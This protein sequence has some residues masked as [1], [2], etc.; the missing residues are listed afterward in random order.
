MKVPERRKRRREILDS[1][2]T[3]TLPSTFS[4]RFAPRRGLREA[5]SANS[6]LPETSTHLH[7]LFRL[8]IPG[9]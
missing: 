8:L 7:S 6:I 4:P 3:P 1:Y 2:R 5:E 9:S